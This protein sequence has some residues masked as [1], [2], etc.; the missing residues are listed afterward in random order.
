MELRLA[1]LFSQN[2]ISVRGPGLLP[3]LSAYSG[4]SL[5]TFLICLV[6]V[7]IELSKTC[8]LSLS[9]VVSLDVSLWEGSGSIVLP[10]ICPIITYT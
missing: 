2:S 7:M 5:R 1:A 3:Y 9:G 4:S 6:Q 8:A 10:R